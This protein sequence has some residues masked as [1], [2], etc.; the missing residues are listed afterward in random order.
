MKKKHVKLNV[1]ILFVVSSF[2][3]TGCSNSNEKKGN[4]LPLHENGEKK[5]DHYEEN[6][7][8]HKHENGRHHNH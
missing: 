6:H 3:F 1:I 8:G 7:E 5:Y 2:A 4:E